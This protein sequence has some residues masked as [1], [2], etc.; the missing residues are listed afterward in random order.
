MRSTATFFFCL[1]LLLFGLVHAATTSTRPPATVC[2]AGTVVKYSDSF[3]DKAGFQGQAISLSGN[4]NFCT[5][6]KMTL[7]IGLAS[8]WTQSARIKDEI[9]CIC[10]TKEA[11]AKVDTQCTG[12]PKK[13]QPKVTIIIDRERAPCVTDTIIISKCSK[14]PEAD[15]AEQCKSGTT[16]PRVSQGFVEKPGTTGAIITGA[17]PVETS[18][19]MQPS[20]PGDSRN[21]LDINNPMRLAATEALNSQNS[22]EK[23]IELLQKLGAT[24]TDDPNKNLAAISCIARGCTDEEWKKAGGAVGLNAN[25]KDVAT[26]Q[27]TGGPGGTVET[28]GGGAETPGRIPGSTFP[29]DQTPT[30]LSEIERAKRAIACIESAC[31][32]YNAIGPTTRNGNNAY[33]KYQVMDFNIPHWTYQACGSAYTPYQFLG[34]QQCQEKVFETRFGGYI[35]ECGSYEGAASKWFSGKCQVTNV[36]DGWTP[37]SKYVQKFANYF[38]NTTIPFGAQ[39]SIYTGGTSPFSQ[40]NLLTGY[41]VPTGYTTQTGEFIPYQPY[42]YTGNSPLSSMFSGLLSRIVSPNTASNTSIPPQTIPS[43][44]TQPAP[45]TS[46][47]A[48]SAGTI[49][50]QPKELARG[51]RIFVSWSSVGMSTVTPCATLLS[52]G[53]SESLI[54]RSNDGSKSITATSTGTYTFSLKCL[55]AAGLPL[56][57]ATTVLV[58]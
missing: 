50:A 37:V 36:S 58:H 48:L 23:Q 20:T 38:G 5:D 40:V 25:L 51:G 53:G 41:S 54:G 34:D 39:A 32:N 9:T 42:G 6:E 33:G 26:I 46:T 31:G 7:S 18:P 55:T 43:T 52:A 4:N 22:Q 3:S 44:G 11:L 57:Q 14:N 21:V 47:P 30:G 12:D 15:F 45:T 16:I 1:S 49:I 29:G 28:P 8:I 27:P 19:S 24:D 35:N 13:Q 10:P 56:Q 2:K 17:N